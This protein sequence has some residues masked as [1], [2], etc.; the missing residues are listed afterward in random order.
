MDAPASWQLKSSHDMWPVFELQA[1]PD[2]QAG[3]ERFVW[4]EAVP[5]RL[6]ISRLLFAAWLI[7]DCVCNTAADVLG[8]VV[9]FLHVLHVLSSVDMC[10]N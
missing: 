3:S 10:D 5:K 1:L 6:V 4:V 8:K 7:L 2:I 9:A